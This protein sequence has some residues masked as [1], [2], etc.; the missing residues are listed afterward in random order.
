VGEEPRDIEQQIEETRERMGDTV[1]A[2]SAKADEPGR[3]RGYVSDKKDAV[4][5]KLTGAK[6][7]VAGG[8]SNM[9]STGG[10]M[11]NSATDAARR[12]AG[13]AKDNPLGLAVG[14]VAV[15]FVAG[16]LLP[17]TKVEN[18]KLGPMADQVKDQARELGSEALE[19]G[20]DIAQETAQQAAETAKQQTREH[21]EQL[22]ESVSQ[23]T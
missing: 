7:T 13:M 17:S 21:S 19:H 5:S 15:G 20:K 12:G 3:V 8:G 11:A 6:D 18:E 14:A 2:L 1:E 9:A 10:D 22:Q 16:T 23:R 4:T